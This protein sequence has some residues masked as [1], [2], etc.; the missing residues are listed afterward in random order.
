MFLVL[1]LRGALA[2]LELSLGWDVNVGEEGSIEGRDAL[3]IDSASFD[4]VL[5]T[6][7]ERPALGVGDVDGAEGRGEALVLEEEEDLLLTG[8]HQGEGRSEVGLLGQ[9]SFA[10][11]REPVA[12]IRRVYIDTYHIFGRTRHEHVI[13]GLDDRV[14]LLESHGRRGEVVVRVV[15]VDVDTPGELAAH[16]LV[17]L[18]RVVTRHPDA[19]VRDLYSLCARKSALSP[20]KVED[21]V[22]HVGP[23]LTDVFGVVELLVDAAGLIDELCAGGPGGSEGPGAL[24]GVEEELLDPLARVEGLDVAAAVL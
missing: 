1:D 2:R 22:R 20:F 15:K 12:Q 5:E 10:Q 17:L 19:I 4:D 23:V 24:R 11:L 6:E 21:V 13:R 14:S 16:V 18:V 7:R 3:K 9:A 8:V